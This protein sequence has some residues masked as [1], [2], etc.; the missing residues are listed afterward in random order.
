MRATTYVTF[1]LLLGLLGAVGWLVWTT[2]EA[3]DGSTPTEGYAAL[4]AGAGFAIIV[5]VGLMA[6]MFHS[7]REGYDEPPHFR[8]DDGR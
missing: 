7:S 8:T 5:G 2:L 1:S 3:P 6:L 4:F